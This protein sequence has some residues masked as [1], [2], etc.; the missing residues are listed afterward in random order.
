MAT[1]RY[2]TDR[3]RSYRTEWTLKQ[4]QQHQAVKINKID[5]G[6][7]VNVVYRTS[8]LSMFQRLSCNRRVDPK[9]VAILKSSIM[10]HGFIGGPIVVNEKMEV[11]DGQ[12]RLAACKE[13]GKDIEYII[14]P[15]L[16]IADC[17]A[18]NQN[19]TIWKMDDY[20]L[21]YA[22]SG[23]EDYIRLFDLLPAV[24]DKRLRGT[25]MVLLV[26]GFCGAVNYLGKR[27]RSGLLRMD[28]RVAAKAAWVYKFLEEHADDIFSTKGRSEYLARAVAFALARTTAS[29][30][31][32]GQVLKERIYLVRPLA[33][34]DDAVEELDKIYNWHLRENAVDIAGVWKEQT[35]KQR[36]KG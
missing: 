21:C 30:Q 18:L 1:M 28:E 29:P 6:E 10:E 31:R 11:V 35:K 25:T 16:E 36:R 19:G 17:I 20:I 4:K 5:K 24:G 2:E 34:M 15:G 12:A 9:R 14:C 26:C 23:M 27:V 7:Q 13:L 33:D 8:D 22:E 32:M 3:E